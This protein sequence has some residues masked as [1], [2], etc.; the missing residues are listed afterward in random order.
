M[1]EAIQKNPALTD[2]INRIEAE[3]L[4]EPQR[5]IIPDHLFCKGIYVR[6]VIFPPMTKVIGRIHKTE[7]I[8][9]LTK[10]VL[11]VFNEETNLWGLMIGP[12][13]AESKI[14]TRRLA[15]VFSET[16]WITYHPTN[17]YPKDDSYEALMDAVKLV[18]EEI[19]EPIDNPYIFEEPIIE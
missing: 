9:T 16:E 4:L 5:K 15:R 13:T 11:E 3:M 17:I 8:Y 18:E 6:K 19:L 2:A 10:G 12:Y 1:T 14:G 7:H